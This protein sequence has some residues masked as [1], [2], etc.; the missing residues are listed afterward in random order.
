MICDHK[1]EKMG[2]HIVCV[3]VCVTE[4][5]EGERN[6]DRKREGEGEGK[7]HFFCTQM[8]T[9]NMSCFKGREGSSEA[10]ACLYKELT[11][12]SVIDCG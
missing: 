12:C 9:K 2:L 6:K 7:E 5:D 11:S 4:R 8:K 3:Y 1:K 10:L